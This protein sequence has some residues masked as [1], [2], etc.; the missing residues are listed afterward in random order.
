MSLPHEQSGSYGVKPVETAPYYNGASSP[1]ESAIIYRNEQSQNQSS[2]NKT[3][4]G[5]KYR[6]R[7]YKGGSDNNDGLVIPSFT[8]SGPQVSAGSQTATGSSIAA[9]TTATQ[10]LSYSVCDSCIGEASNSELCQGP[11]C[12]PNAQTGGSCSSCNNSGLIPIG[13]TWGC[14][15]GGKRKTK[16]S[17]KTMKAKKTKKSKKTMKSKKSKKAMKSKKIRKTMKKRK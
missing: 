8:T 10:G 14:M 7:K 16:K 1:R 13:K 5:K 2:M 9:N 11:Q 17:K 4:G 15:S 12:N 3:Y 6:R